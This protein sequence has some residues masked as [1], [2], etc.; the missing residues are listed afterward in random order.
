MELIT[1]QQH[2]VLDMRSIVI[3]LLL[4]IITIQSC[5]GSNPLATPLPYS[6]S[7]LDSTPVYSSS[8]CF[9]SNKQ[10]SSSLEWRSNACALKNLCFNTS[11]KELVFFAKD[12]SEIPEWV[13]IA[14]FNLKWARQYDDSVRYRPKIV[15]GPIP[16]GS[17]VS[18]SDELWIPYLPFCPANVGHVIW[19]DF[20]SIFSLAKTVL[21]FLGM[22][23]WYLRLL[24][25]NVPN[26]PPCELWARFHVLTSGPPI[27]Y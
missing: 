13:S 9:S 7:R 22:K 16:S 12:E 17:W 2:K 25:Y 21:P 26:D 15:H 27:V 18:P 14:T 5:F 4:C 23:D 3:V 20:L 10:D 1:T 19:D 8:H 6:F 24:W 11:T